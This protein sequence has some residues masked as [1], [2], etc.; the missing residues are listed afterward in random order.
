MTTDRDSM[1]QKLRTRLAESRTFAARADEI[2][3]RVGGKE[4]VRVGMNVAVERSSDKVAPNG[5]SFHV[6]IKASTEGIARDAGIIPMSAWRDGGLANFAANPVILAYHDH[7]SPIGIAVHTMLERSDM[8]QYW[9]FHEE[10]DLSRTMKKLYEGGYMRAASVGFIVK[11]FKFIDEL[12][13]SE[14]ENLVQK[15]G[16]TVIRDIFWIA[17]KAELL[18]TSAVP[19]PADPGALQFQDATRSAQAVGID[20]SSLLREA[21]IMPDPT[22]APIIES[23]RTVDSSPD[24][25]ALHTEIAEL[26]AVVETQAATIVTLQASVEEIRTL[27]AEIS[28]RQTIE[29]APAVNGEGSPAVVEPPTDSERTVG[30]VG[31]KID[32]REGETLDEAFNRHVDTKARS[33][34]GAPIPSK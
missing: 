22:P 33:M 15:Y 5:E 26:R 11:E 31:I 30:T 20:I 14:L 3:N 8:V 6:K 27:V 9:R 4:Q 23:S 12:S 10:T 13:D 1:L 28:T 18:E 21:S 25:S 32:V 24:A 29:V 19:V 34:M 7:R 17:T 16:A 2:I